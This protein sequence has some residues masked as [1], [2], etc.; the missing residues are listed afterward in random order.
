MVGWSSGVLSSGL[1]ADALIAE[2]TGQIGQI[3]LGGR[4]RS[5]KVTKGHG[6]I[7]RASDRLGNLAR[8][9]NKS[10]QTT[11]FERK[12][13]PVESDVFDAS[14]KDADFFVRKF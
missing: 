12:Y 4:Q 13:K 2:A 14:K 8:F 10:K 3:G 1:V 5:R 9:K 11:N 7:A 6:K